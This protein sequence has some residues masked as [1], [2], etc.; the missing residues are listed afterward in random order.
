MNN[1]TN[2]RLSPP[3]KS[4]TVILVECAKRSC[5]AQP[6]QP[7]RAASGVPTDRSHDQRYGRLAVVMDQYGDLITAHVMQAYADGIE[8]GRLDPEHP[9]LFELFDALGNPLRTEPECN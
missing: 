9:P 4:A 3:E 6:T 8:T 7:C 5:R 2:P 1:I